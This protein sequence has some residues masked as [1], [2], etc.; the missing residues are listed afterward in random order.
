MAVNGAT[1][2]Y[3][4]DDAS[5][6]TADTKFLVLPIPVEGGAV[7]GPVR[8]MSGL[9]DALDSLVAEHDRIGSPLG[10]HLRRRSPQEIEPLLR[11]LP[12]P[13]ASG[14]TQW[15]ELLACFAQ[16]VE[17]PSAWDSSSLTSR[18]LGQTIAAKDPIGVQGVSR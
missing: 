17:R 15:F 12:D 1:I 7:H 6:L 14:A 5:Q 4:Y 11:G 9:G 8:S 13:V 3:T 18:D 16:V 10:R 2:G